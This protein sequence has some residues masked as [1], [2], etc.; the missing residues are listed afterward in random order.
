MSK[1]VY[2][3]RPEFVPGIRSMEKRQTIRPLPARRPNVGDTAD[4][5]KWKGAPYRSG[6]QKIG[7]WPITK[8]EP[9]KVSEHGVW[10]GGKVGPIGPEAIVNLAKAEGFSSAYA[11]FEWLE[12][13]YRFPF[14]GLLI[15]W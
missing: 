8:V 3:F 6:Q 12:L 10:L 11:F 9:I 4:C 1:F 7:E 14:L 15:R 2:L 5:R 13:T